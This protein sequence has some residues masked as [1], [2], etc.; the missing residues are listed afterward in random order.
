MKGEQAEDN[1][2]VPDEEDQ[3]GGLL[4][5]WFWLDQLLLSG[6]GSLQCV[7]KGVQ[8]IA[9]VVNRAIFELWCQIL[10][11]KNVAGFGILEDGE[12]LQVHNRDRPM[13]APEVWCMP[14]HD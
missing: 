1:L 3:G 14:V 9:N 6:M 7:R 8:K 5:L 10:K 12:P 4:S 11:I 2:Q 13:E